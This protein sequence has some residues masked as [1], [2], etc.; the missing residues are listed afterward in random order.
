VVPLGF[1]TTIIITGMPT[2]ASASCTLASAFMRHTH[3]SAWPGGA[4]GEGRHFQRTKRETYNTRVQ[5]KS[6]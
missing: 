6:P 4:G 2:T 3:C 5:S 1:H